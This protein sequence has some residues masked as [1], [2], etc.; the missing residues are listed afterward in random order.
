MPK[1][2][3]TSQQVK[4][5][6]D[7]T[8][9]N[10][11]EPISLS[12]CDSKLDTLFSR[13]NEHY[14]IPLY[15]RSFDWAYDNIEKLIDDI[16]DSDAQEYYLGSLIVYLDPMD[17]FEVVD[18]QQ[19]LTTL[20]LLLTVLK[21][22]YGYDFKLNNCLQFECREK[23]DKI[24]E[25]LLSSNSNELSDDDRETSIFRAMQDIEAVLAQRF[26]NETGKLKSNDPTSSSCI[27]DFVER[28]CRVRLF[29]IC[30]PPGTDLNLYFEIMNTRG[31]QLEQHD[32]IKSNLME[33]LDSEDRNGFDC[34]WSACSNMNR[35]VQMGFKTDDRVKLFGDD[36]T[37]LPEHALK[38]LRTADKAKPDRTIESVLFDTVEH[39]ETAHANNADNDSD[40]G[41]YK[42]IIDFPV[43]LLHVLRV[44]LECSDGAYGKNVNLPELL[45]D[46][47]LLDEYKNVVQA[48]P[49][50]SRRQLSEDF[51]EC[52]LRCR[53]L[54]DRYIIKRKNCG[55]EGFEYRDGEWSLKKLVR[56]GDKPEYKY[57]EFYASNTSMSKDSLMLQSALRVSYTSP[58]VMHW[59][60]TALSWLYNNAERVDKSY[61]DIIE[62]EAQK[63]VRDY[64]AEGDYYR[65]VNTPRIVF[66][67]LDYLLWHDSKDSNFRF[68]F[69]NSV[70]HW[71]PRNP[72]ENT[73]ESWN[74]RTDDSGKYLRDGIG[75]L[76]LVSNSVNSQFSNL[77]PESKSQEYKSLID[78]GSLKL[79]KMRDLIKEEKSSGW[80]KGGCERH[81]KEMI[82]KL[83]GA[84]G[85]YSHEP[86]P[87]GGNFYQP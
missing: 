34:I 29:R 16:N 42:S 39:K 61:L 24:I 54:F 82:D 71:Y 46:N 83:R 10:P 21:N 40:V 20:L 7:D 1:T 31:E 52:L 37:A 25:A 17:R 70:E 65:G 63:G 67:Y 49:E 33:A 28:L 22:D 77:S 84:C 86:E 81:G 9:V 72:S 5:M 12:I 56:N 6:K 41:Q 43:F 36:W 4:T 73:F 8:A 26:L 85:L 27:S 23:S 11:A 2:D 59:I 13:F 68:E 30:V 45:N 79:R 80:R 66:N 55:E 53:C 14:V 60:T 48:T 51:I 78:G 47:K 38:T 19:R 18:G 62:S 76:C 44:F 64:L 35:Y 57:T 32:I 74:D 69:R 3:R 87:K 75:N 58:R 50:S 15:Q